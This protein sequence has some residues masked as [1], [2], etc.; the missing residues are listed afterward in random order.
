[1]AASCRFA[2]AIHIMA[3]LAYED[4]QR[5]QGLTSEAIARSVNTNPVVIRRILCDL[6]KAGLVATHKGASGG[7]RLAREPRSIAL[8]AVY[9]AVHGGPSFS[10][11]PQQPD[12]RC[13]VGRKIELV[14]EEV[15]A[16]AEQALQ[17]ALSL[18]TLAD[19][20]EDVTATEE[21][22]A[23]TKE[24]AARPNALA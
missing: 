19:V 6:K 4:R 8:D 10:A 23:S 24:P 18:R 2:F 22:G 17:H 21:P 14:L 13:P 1:M 5:E 11:H 3:V 9:R 20:L 16:S 7:T 12:Q 15:F